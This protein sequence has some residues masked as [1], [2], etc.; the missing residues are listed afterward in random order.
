MSKPRPKKIIGN[1][2]GARS[3][4]PDASAETIDTIASSANPRTMGDTGASDDT[5][6]ARV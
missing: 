6:L 2:R 4:R 5:H 3:I 1:D